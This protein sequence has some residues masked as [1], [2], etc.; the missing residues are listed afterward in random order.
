M[1]KFNTEMKNILERI[2]SNRKTKGVT[3]DL[4]TCKQ[5]LSPDF[6]ELEGCVLLNIFSIQVPKKINIEAI[7][8]VYGDRTGYEASRNE[9]RVNDYLEIPKNKE[10]YLVEV[11]LQ[12]LEVW[13]LKLKAK[14]PESKFCFIVSYNEG[15]V[16]IRFHKIRQNEMNWLADDLEEYEEEGIL[17]KVI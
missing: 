13:G 8:N 16:T 12:L 14:F 3:I 6:L 11:A 9:L 2:N 7:L 5:F 10:Y 15:Y 1:M 17:T 4:N